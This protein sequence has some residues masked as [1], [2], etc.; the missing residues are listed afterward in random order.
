MLTLDASSL[1]KAME[2]ETFTPL[3]GKIEDG[4]KDKKKLS[5]TVA[6]E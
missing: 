1:I 6:A 5:V 2:T 4:T 3:Q